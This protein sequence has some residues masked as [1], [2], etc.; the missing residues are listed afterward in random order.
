MLWSASPWAICGFA[1]SGAWRTATRRD[2]RDRPEVAERVAVDR[3]NIGT[4]AGE[5]P[6]SF[7]GPTV[8]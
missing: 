6:R 5:F 8:R 1:P 7:S 4:S 2:P 3:Q